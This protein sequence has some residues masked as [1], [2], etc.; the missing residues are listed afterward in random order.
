VTAWT[1]RVVAGCF[2]AALGLLAAACGGATAGGQPGVGTPPPTPGVSAGTFAAGL[3]EFF[4]DGLVAAERGSFGLDRARVL[5]SDD[6]R[7]RHLLR[8]SYPAGSASERAARTDGTSH[9]G[10]QLYLVRRGGA[11]DALNLRYYVRFPPGFDF[12]KGGKLPGLFGGSV[13]NDREIPDGTNGFSTRYMWRRA[14]AGEVYAYLPTSVEQGTS[15]GRGFWTWTPGRWICVEQRVRLNTPGRPDGT[16]TV[17]VD[18]ERVYEATGLVFR[19]TA[20]LKIDG[21]YFSTFFGGGDR[22]WATPRDQHADF[23]AFAVSGDYIGPGP[24]QKE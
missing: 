4:G 7:F 22:S 16:V 18:G 23:A 1:G 24:N 3:Q 14:G 17:W 6:Q 15:L 21:L 5:P 13:T 19:T 20:D 11:T 9:G 12:V 2:A 8:V 10:A